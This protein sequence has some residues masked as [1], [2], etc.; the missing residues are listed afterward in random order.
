MGC[1]GLLLGADPVTYQNLGAPMR[2]G[3]HAG[4]ISRVH[5]PCGEPGL[6]H[7]LLHLKGTIFLKNLEYLIYFLLI[8]SSLLD[9]KHLSLSNLSA[10]IFCGEHLLNHRSEVLLRDLGA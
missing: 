8:I 4:S 9:P 10:Q 6:I 1:S 7:H 3:A 2:C 5:G